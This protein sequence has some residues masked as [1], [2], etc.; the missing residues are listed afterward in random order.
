MRKGE[1]FGA[2]GEGDVPQREGSIVI[3]GAGVFSRAQK[4]AESQARHVCKRLLP[5]GSTGGVRAIEQ[6]RDQSHWDRLHSTGRGI[7]FVV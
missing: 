4:E 5:C 6:V 3:C 7:Q 1:L 2:N